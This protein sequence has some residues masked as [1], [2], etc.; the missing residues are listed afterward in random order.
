MFHL[1]FDLF[2]FFW[3]AYRCECEQ[4]QLCVGAVE[5]SIILPFSHI[6]YLLLIYVIFSSYSDPSHYLEAFWKQA[7]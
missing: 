3:S 5:M 7:I 2:P 4:N 6:I 1:R